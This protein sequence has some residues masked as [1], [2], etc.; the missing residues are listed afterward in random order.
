MLVLGALPGL[1]Q[2][3]QQERNP[4]NGYYYTRY[5]RRTILVLL[6]KICLN[7]APKLREDQA[8][9]FIAIDYSSLVFSLYSIDYDLQ[10]EKVD[11]NLFLG[12]TKRIAESHYNYIDKGYIVIFIDKPIYDI[13]PNIPLTH[14]ETF[15]RDYRGLL[16]GY[17]YNAKNCLLNYNKIAYGKYKSKSYHFELKEEM[18][19][20]IYNKIDSSSFAKRTLTD[21]ISYLMNNLYNSNISNISFIV[22]IDSHTNREIKSMYYYCVIRVSREIN[23]QELDG[24]QTEMIF[25][26]WQNTG[27][28]KAWPFM[29]LA[30]HKILFELSNFKKPEGKRYIDTNKNNIAKLIVQ[31]DSIS[32]SFHGEVVYS[33]VINNH[34]KTEIISERGLCI[35]L[36][37]ENKP[38]NYYARFDIMIVPIKYQ[39]LFH[40]LFGKD[41]EIIKK[42][43][44]DVLRNFLVSAI[45]DSNTRVVRNSYYYTKYNEECLLII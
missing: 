10:S 1:D 44:T 3:L 15:K 8:N 5:C 17:R 18:S 27:N 40:K 30:F 20:K 36:S 45:L 24:Q 9:S 43:K 7:L 4:H 21:S 26:Q 25:E 23:Q 35:H 33:Y 34:A 2:K 13:R 29:R 28:D 22:S 37:I 19:T 31:A 39:E 38:R 11:N 42:E 12:W 32:Y 6:D 16:T 14:Q 41:E